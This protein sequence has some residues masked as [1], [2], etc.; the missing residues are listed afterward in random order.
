M[1]LNSTIGNREKQTQTMRIA[2]LLHMAQADGAHA[3]CSHMHEDECIYIYTCVYIC[4]Y[5]E[6]ERERDSQTS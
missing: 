5:I 2:A 4:I 3:V 1:A 6:R